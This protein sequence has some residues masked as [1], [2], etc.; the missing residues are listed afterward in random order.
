MSALI[1]RVDSREI[2]HVAMPIGGIGT[3]TVALC[4]DGSLRQWQLHNIGNH[5]GALPFSF[6]AIRAT[7]IEPPLDEVRVLQAAAI[8]ESTHTPLV[9]DDVA[10]AWQ[11]DLLGR[12]HGMQR[13]EFGGTYPMATVEYFDPALPLTVELEAF[14]PLVPLD[15]ADSSIPVAQFTFRITNTD[16]LPIHGT[17]GVTAQNAVG[18]DGISPIAGVAGAG[19]GG[20][21]NRVHRAGGW[22]SVVMENNGLPA[23]S[24]AAGQMVLGVDHPR[25]SVLTQWRDPDEFITFLRSRAL[26]S[27]AF[28]LDLDRS[29]P[30]P[31]RH[32][33]RAA[34]GPSGPGT[35]WN[36]GI[37]VPFDLPAEGTTEIRVLLA[38][39]FPNR[40]VDFEQFGPPR[41][42]W[43]NSRFWLGNHYAGVYPSA[44]AVADDVIARWSTLHDATVKWTS[45]F[46]DSS[47][48]EDAVTHLAAQLSTIRSPTCF[49]TAD[50]RFFGFEGVL[51]VSTALWSGEF[52]GSCPL[53]CTHVWNYE[54]ALAA[55]FPELDRSMRETEFDVMQAPEGYVPH[56]VAMPVYLRQFWGEPIGGPEEPALDGMLGCVLKTYREV[57]RGAGT[58]VAAPLLAECGA[59]ARPHQD[60]MGPDPER[61]AAGRP[62]QH[63]RHRSDRA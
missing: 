35:T 31:Q 9:A 48:D 20:N 41:P 63:S 19:Y 4:S 10:P 32:A 26:A 2:P 6:F 61:D 50:G 25:A 60:E 59:A 42:E 51:G 36:T 58:A 24:P 37:G 47:L 28:R 38:W 21:T 16:P 57:R 45:V 52:G 53:N 14:N 30:D 27:G 7:R 43:G 55:T 44:Q 33:P 5:A 54:Q 18:W 49:R 22:T 1:R 39:H 29:I 11:H 8:P 3:G 46:A 40:F 34:V 62:A 15:V 17:L 56:R 23:D 12:H 13:V